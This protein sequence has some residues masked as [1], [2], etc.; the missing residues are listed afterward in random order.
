[1]KEIDRS[2][3]EVIEDTLKLNEEEID[4]MYEKN[5]FLSRVIPSDIVQTIHFFEKFGITREEMK[6][7]SLVN[8]WFLTESFE[9][10]R[11]IEKFLKIVDITDIR[12]MAVNHPLS[13]S[14]NPITI[15][16]FIEKN[17]SEG[18]SDEKIR[19]LIKNDFDKYFHV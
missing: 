4:R 10:I 13:M 19:E 18:K 14:I 12:W 7:I 6:Q 2:V 17:R 5:K 1:M 11:Y 16:D 9:R 8:Y 15:K 3:Y